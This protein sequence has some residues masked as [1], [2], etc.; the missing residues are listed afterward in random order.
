ME[1]L[2]Q[3]M[4]SLVAPRARCTPADY[5]IQDMPVPSIAMPTQVLMRMHAASVGPGELQAMAGSMGRFVTT[6]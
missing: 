2:P 4:R 3:T 1:D 6:E 5:L